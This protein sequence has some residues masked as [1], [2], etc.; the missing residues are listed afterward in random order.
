MGNV[1]PALIAFTSTV[2]VGYGAHFLAEDYRRFRDSTAIAAA[3]A[4]EMGSIVLSF[5]GLRNVLTEMKDLLDEE[6]AIALPEM[7]DQSSPIFEA[8]AEKVGMLGGEGRFR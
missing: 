1:V 7:P 3:L 8:N 4:G 2:L 5:P 6:K